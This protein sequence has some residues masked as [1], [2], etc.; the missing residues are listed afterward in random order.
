[1]KDFPGIPGGT[2]IS[3]QTS[4]GI[5]DKSNITMNTSIQSTRT[6][7]VR[8]DTVCEGGHCLRGDTVCEGYTVYEGDT[9]YEG[10]H[11]L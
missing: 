8:G 2:P 10:G 9:V 5:R 1:M 6:Q 4:A 11:S 7:S 3:E